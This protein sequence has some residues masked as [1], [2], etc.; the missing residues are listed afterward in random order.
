MGLKSFVRPYAVR[1]PEQSCRKY[2]SNDSTT[3]TNSDNSN[4]DSSGNDTIINLW[5]CASRPTL[6]LS[7][8]PFSTCCFSIGGRTSRASRRF[9]IAAADA[10][11]LRYLSWRRKEGIIPFRLLTHF[12]ARLAM[13]RYRPMRCGASDAT[14]YAVF[15]PFSWSDAADVASH[16]VCW[17]CRFVS[18]RNMDEKNDR[19]EFS[20]APIEK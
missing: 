16:S 12:S 10:T 7:L 3:I 1:I 17:L 6:W 13:R 19:E 15:P 20:S 4:N 2:G 11:T 8:V 14:I 18:K 5:H 9:P